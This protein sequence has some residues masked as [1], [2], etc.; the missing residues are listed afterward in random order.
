M[1]VETET[2]TAAAAERPKETAAPPSAA[3]A[4]LQHRPAAAGPAPCATPPELRF[5]YPDFLALL[6][7]EEAQPVVSQIKVFINDFRATY[8]ETLTVREQVSLFRE[9]RDRLA[10]SLFTNPVWVAAG[11]EAQLLGAEGIE[12]I[13]MNQLRRHAFCPKNSDDQERD[14]KIAKQLA[15]YSWVGLGHLGL[16][17]Q[18]QLDEKA[19]ADAARYFHRV[20]DSATPR[21]KLLCLL[22]GVALLEQSIVLQDGQALNADLFMP[23]QILALLKAQPAQLHSNLH[24]ISRFRNAKYLANETAYKFTN[25]MAAMS[26][27]ERLDQSKLVVEQADFDVQMEAAVAQYNA[28]SIAK[29]EESTRLHDEEMARREAEMIARDQA[30]QAQRRAAGQPQGRQS[31]FGRSGSAE[32][33]AIWGDLEEKSKVLV[34]KAKNSELLHKSRGM[35]ASFVTEAKAR[36]N[37]IVE[38]LKKEDELDPQA[39]GPPRK[40]DDE[41][42]FQLQLA[43]AISLSEAEAMQQHQDKGKERAEPPCAEAAVEA[44]SALL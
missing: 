11:V 19:F 26:F 23:V 29:Q 39:K 44:R 12:F 43:M 4:K 22:R 42:E 41:E 2:P 30:E 34:E 28:D 17:E 36:V 8:S 13:T 9:F 5:S 6:K 31:P 15:L 16:A 10:D 24:Y 32:L 3:D 40:L 7:L 27:I 18:V 37:D 38:D 20:N 33:K 25:I 35:W 21:D 1:P 14:E